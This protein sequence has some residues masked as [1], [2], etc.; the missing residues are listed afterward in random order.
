VAIA[1][2]AVLRD[3]SFKDAE[4]TVQRNSMRLREFKSRFHRLARGLGL[5]R[6]RLRHAYWSVGK[7]I[8]CS[9]DKGGTLRIRLLIFLI[10]FVVIKGR[11][12]QGNTANRKS[13]YGFVAR[14]SGAKRSK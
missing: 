12:H 3:D 13:S 14:R 4:L 8:T 1:K 11:R 9:L 6:T 10:N 5:P 2:L 7:V